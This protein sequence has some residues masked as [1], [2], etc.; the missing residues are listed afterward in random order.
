MESAFVKPRCLYEMIV[1]AD[2]LI[3]IIKS[4]LPT[5]SSM[6]AR[7]FIASSAFFSLL[8]CFVTDARTLYKGAVYDYNWNIRKA[9][10]D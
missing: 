3:E 5:V 4:K 8:F 6:K 2:L 7:S 1:M 9:K 10:P